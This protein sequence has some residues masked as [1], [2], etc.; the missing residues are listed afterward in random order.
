M[1]KEVLQIKNMVCDRCKMS[2]SSIL[3]D[4]DIP[5]RSVSLG[6]VVLERPIVDQ[7]KALLQEEFSKVGFWLIDDRNEGLVNR[8]KTI[9]IEEVYQPRAT[10]GRKLSEILAATLLYDYTYLSS[11]FKRMEKISIEKFCSNLKIER[12]KEL[13]EYGELNIN[14]IAAE[15][16][17]NSVSY[18]CTKF[19]KETG[20]TPLAYQKK[21][22]RDRKG[23][24]TL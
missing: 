5:F 24:S 4:L 7:E 6:E 16:G 21:H 1:K 19:K 13:L 20:L 18:F 17:Y 15:I 10:P 2:V 9:I 3:T 22:Y 23:L 12:T 11:L 8:I 14:E